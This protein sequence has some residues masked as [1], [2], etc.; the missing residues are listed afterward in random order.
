MWSKF[1]DKYTLNYSNE[2]VWNVDFTYFSMYLFEFD[3]W[4][5]LQGLSVRSGAEVLRP[6]AF[7]SCCRICPAVYQ[8]PCILSPMPPTKLGNWHFTPLKLLCIDWMIWGVSWLNA[9]CCNYVAYHSL[10][11]RQ[12]N[13]GRLSSVVDKLGVVIHFVHYLFDLLAVIGHLTFLQKV[14]QL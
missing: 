6:V 14:S 3:R 9:E 7:S 11:V 2:N 13:V 1:P 4:Y 12:L 8:L 5:I 10:S